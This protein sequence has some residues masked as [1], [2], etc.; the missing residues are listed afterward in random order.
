MEKMQTQEMI[1]EI[2]RAKKEESYQIEQIDDNT[3]NLEG[4]FVLEEKGLEGPENIDES[5][6]SEAIVNLGL[7]EVEN[8]GPKWENEKIQIL[9]END[10]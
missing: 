1:K 5:S 6:D 3:L 10:E 2:Q 9:G 4:D 8:P 7:E